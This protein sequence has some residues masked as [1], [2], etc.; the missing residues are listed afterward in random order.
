MAT[1]QHIPR[2]RGFSDSLVYFH[3]E[4]DYFTRRQGSCTVNTSDPEQPTQHLP[5]VDL[6]SDDAPAHALNASSGDTY[7]EYIFKAE[8]LRVIEAHA[9]ANANAQLPRPLFLFYAAHVAHQPYEVPE[10]Y[11]QSFAFIPDGQR[12]AYHAMVKCLDDVLKEIVYALQA[13]QLWEDLLM[14]MST[15]NGGPIFAGANN[16]PLRGSKYR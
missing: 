4:N 10:S 16:F 15:D 13:N 11:N 12:R 2:G 6:W 5:C 1:P 3:H 14:V 7:E 9:M 8:A